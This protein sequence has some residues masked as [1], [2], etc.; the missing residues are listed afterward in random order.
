M[1][2]LKKNF[3]PTKSYLAST[4]ANNAVKNKPNAPGKIAISN[5]FPNIVEMETESSQ[6]YID[7]DTEDEEY[8]DVRIYLL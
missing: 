6:N 2:K 7:N 1:P 4:Y 8:I 3:L 5:P